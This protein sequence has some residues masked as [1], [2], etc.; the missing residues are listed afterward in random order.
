MVSL[1]SKGD[2]G[3]GWSLAWKACLWARLWEGSRCWKLICRLLKPVYSTDFNYYDG[4][5]TYINFMNAHP[6][7][8]I[9]GNFSV[10]AAIA[11]MLLQSHLGFVHLLPALPDAWPNGQDGVLVHA[12]VHTN[13]DG[14]VKLR[15]RNIEWSVLLWKGDNIIKIPNI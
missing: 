13:A 9:D 4:G 12:A 6:L 8:Q 10:T 1:D 5:G 2:E 11:E 3:T 7:F 15:Y 14:E